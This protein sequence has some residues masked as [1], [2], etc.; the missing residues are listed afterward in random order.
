MTHKTGSLL[1]CRNVQ[2]ASELHRL[3][4]HNADRAAL[5]AGVTNHHVRSVQ[6]LHLQEMA[7]IDHGLNDRTHIVSLVRRIRDQGVQIQIVNG[8]HGLLVVLQG[9]GLGKVV[10]RQELQKLTHKIE[11]VFFILSQVG[12]GAGHGVVLTRTTEGLHVHILAGHG[13]NDVRAGN[14]HV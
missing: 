3:V 7:V 4:R 11:R 1:G 5:N 6:R 13:L 14:E 10:R 12:A 8:H 2:A 9:Q